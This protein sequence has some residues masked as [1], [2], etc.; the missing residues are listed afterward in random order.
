RYAWYNENAGEQ[1]HP[2]GQ[3]QPNPWGLYDMHGNV[4][5]WVQD[6]NGKYTSRTA[7]DPAGPSSGSFRMIRA[8]GWGNAALGCRVAL[9]FSGAPGGRSDDLGFRLLMVAQ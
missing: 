4:E 8:C 3:L 2:V 9:R 1:T 7:V 5:E 6:W